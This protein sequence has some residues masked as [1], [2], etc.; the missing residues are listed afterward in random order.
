LEARL[1][2]DGATPAD[3]A[4]TLR[5]NA[6]LDTPSPANWDDPALLALRRSEL[7]HAAV[8]AA[9]SLIEMLVRLRDERARAVHLREGG[10]VASCT[11][12][13]LM[14]HRALVGY[15]RDTLRSDGEAVSRETIACVHGSGVMELVMR[16]LGE[17]RGLIT[18]RMQALPW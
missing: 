2:H 7:E 15:R 14:L 8:G 9:E 1:R 17:L 4:L 5:L 3:P 11:R 18:A 16:A 13:M 12:S 6:L 10:C